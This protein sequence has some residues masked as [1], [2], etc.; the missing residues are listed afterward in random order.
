MIQKQDLETKKNK[1]CVTL[2]RYGCLYVEADSEEEAR[3]IADH[4][5]TD[6]V[7]WSDDWGPTDVEE[8]DSAPQEEYITERAF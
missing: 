4:Q 7:N 2:T 8:D 5:T 3:D 6:T 1:Y